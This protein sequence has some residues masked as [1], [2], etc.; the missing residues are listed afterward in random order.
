MATQAQIDAN[1]RNAEKS[2]GACTPEGKARSRR[3][4]TRHGLCS[5]I[6]LMS[7]EKSED[8]ASLLADLRHEHQPDGPT[9]DILVY[10][11][12]Q[13]F[14]FANRAQFLLADR[15]GDPSK[16]D[17]SKQVALMLRYH[18]TSD[19]AF[20]K[21]L[22]DL[23]KL[24]KEHRKEEIGFVSQTTQPQP[25]APP[26]TPPLKPRPAASQPAAAPIASEIRSLRPFAAPLSLR[27]AYRAS[28][29]S[30]LNAA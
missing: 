19:R 15:L 24:Q 23:R 16:E 9:E 4:A 25:G 18:T 6:A 20:N 2:T 1:R 12:A 30:R 13:S 17:N 11:M 26:D 10:K 22:N 21:H 14:F 28:R 5:G 3:N 29:Q 27:E 7:N 8:F